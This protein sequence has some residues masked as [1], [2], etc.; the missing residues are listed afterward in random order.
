MV[1]YCTY[2]STRIGHRRPPALSTRD[3]NHNTK[4][5]MCYCWWWWWWW[6]WEGGRKRG[7]SGCRALLGKLD[8]QTGCR[9][10]ATR[11]VKATKF[12]PPS[13]RRQGVSRE[14]VSSVATCG[15]YRLEALPSSASLP[16]SSH[17]TKGT[18][19]G[20]C[21]QVLTQ[22]WQ[23]YQ[24]SKT[25]V[26]TLDWNQTREEDWTDRQSESQD[27]EPGRT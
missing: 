3:T 13:A 22:G 12:S 27:H 1:L 14:G 25:R 20:A 17:V 10:S 23:P 19:C 18:V 8:G 15:A 2:T 26:N 6:W 24:A 16:G 5:S 11:S 9:P 4:R 21:W 7:E